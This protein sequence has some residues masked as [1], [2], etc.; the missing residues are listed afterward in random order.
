MIM[1]GCF[2]G[3]FDSAPDVP[4]LCDFQGGPTPTLLPPRIRVTHWSRYGSSPTQDVT[5]PGVPEGS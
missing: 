4:P 1:G 3:P 5:E 2:Q